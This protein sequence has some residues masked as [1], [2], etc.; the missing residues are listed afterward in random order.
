MAISL[1][2][3]A[4]GQNLSTSTM[5]ITCIRR[6]ALLGLNTLWR[7]AICSSQ[8]EPGKMHLGSLHMGL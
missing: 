1:C 6:M 4:A 7:E 2:L 5:C 8:K 3:V